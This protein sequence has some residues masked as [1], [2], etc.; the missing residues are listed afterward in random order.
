VAR[1]GSRRGGAYRVL[2]R[3]PEGWRPLGGPRHSYG[4]NIKVNLQEVGW[5][6]MGWIDLAQDTDKRRAVMNAVMNLRVS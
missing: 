4:D 6:G 1:T 2:A 5:V 3:K